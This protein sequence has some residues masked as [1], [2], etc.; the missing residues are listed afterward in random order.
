MAQITAAEGT[1]GG[2]KAAPPSVIGSAAPAAG[3][4]PGVPGSTALVV[5]PTMEE[6]GRAALVVSPT[7]P[8]FLRSLRLLIKKA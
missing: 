1:K 4:D 6:L 5:S 2:G 7:D 8:T 3:P